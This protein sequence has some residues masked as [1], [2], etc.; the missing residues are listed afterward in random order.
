MHRT[1]PTLEPSNETHRDP[2]H[3]PHR[4]ATSDAID[5]LVVCASQAEDAIRQLARL[6]L[7]APTLAPADIDRI[8]GHLAETI[9]AIPQV[10]TQL[11]Q[12]LDRSGDSYDLAM[13]GMTITTDPDLAIDTARLHLHEARHPAL[14]TYRASTPPAPKSPTSAPPRATTWTK[15]QPRSLPRRLEDR[16]PPPSQPPGQGHRGPAR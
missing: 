8:L 12:T 6:T 11:S 13:D 4:D 9:A 2:N 7:Q 15:V 10:T 1:D 14:L 5:E 3:D 16:Q